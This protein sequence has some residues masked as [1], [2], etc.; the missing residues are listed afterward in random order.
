M[1]VRSEPSR[2]D[3]DRGIE[4]LRYKHRQIRKQ[5]DEIEGLPHS[6]DHHTPSA[7]AHHP[8]RFS[9]AEGVTHHTRSGSSAH[10]PLAAETE[11]GRPP[12]SDPTGA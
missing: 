1:A 11:A 5:Q 9:S 7:R 12:P 4:A 3:G 2:S 6:Y 10:A 8:P